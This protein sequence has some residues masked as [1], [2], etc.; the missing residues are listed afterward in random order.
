MFSLAAEQRSAIWLVFCFLLPAFSTPS[1]T[2]TSGTQR[3]SFSL[4]L[5]DPAESRNPV[6][7]EYF[8][9]VTFFCD[10]IFLVLHRP[11]ARTLQPFWGGRHT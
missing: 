8:L 7:F 4:V 10:D 3:F 6:I 11:V 9:D 2:S 5:C 1:L